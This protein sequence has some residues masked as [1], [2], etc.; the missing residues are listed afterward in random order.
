MSR[1]RSGQAAEDAEGEEVSQR[2]MLMLTRSKIAAR[3]TVP[4]RMSRR[5]PSLPSSGPT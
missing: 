4:A 5:R 3:Q 2:E 1:L